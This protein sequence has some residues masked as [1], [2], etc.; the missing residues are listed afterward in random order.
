T[1][2]PLAFRSNMKYV[3]PLCRSA[4]GSDRNSPNAISANGAR[5]LQIFCPFSSQPPS[6]LVAVDR[7][8]ARSLPDSGSDQACPQ[9]CSPLPLLGNIRSSCFSVPCA[10]SV[11]ASIDVPLALA[12][13]GAPARKYSSS[14]TT[15]CSSGASRPPYFFGQVIT[16]RPASNNT[17]SQWR[18]CAK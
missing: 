8:D 15:Q 5:E 14:N 11:G 6:V 2:M 7:S 12:R 10:N 3:S 18:C 1:V 9:V 17:R 4:A 13:P 16:D